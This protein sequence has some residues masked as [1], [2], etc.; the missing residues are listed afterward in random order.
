MSRTIKSLGGWATVI[1][2]IIHSREFLKLADIGG[3][4]QYHQ[5]GNAL[6]H[7]FLVYLEAQKMFPNNEMMQCVALLHDIGKI[8]VSRQKLNG[9]WEYPNHSIV[10]AELLDAFIDPELV[11]FKEMQWFIRNHIK[12]LFWRDKGLTREQAMRTLS[13]HPSDEIT[14]ETFNNLIDL[15]ICD[16][17][18]SI[19]ADYTDTVETI[20]YLRSLKYEE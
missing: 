6:T 5:E 14:V 9:D 4:H 3:C 12:P 7:T 18:G 16:L 19:P 1:H 11:C 15:V 10:G 17:Q 8:L 20:N 2:E 13:E